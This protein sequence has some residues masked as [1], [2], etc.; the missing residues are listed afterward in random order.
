MKKEIFLLFV[1]LILCFISTIF[2]SSAGDSN[3][4]K[5]ST[6]YTSSTMTTCEGGKCTKIIYSGT[7][8]VY[9]DNVWKNIENARSLKN[10]SISCIVKEDEFASAECLDYNTTSI[11]LKIKLKDESLKNKDIDIKIKSEKYDKN[12]T[13][14]NFEKNVKKI[15]LR[16]LGDESINLLNCNFGEEI[17]I[18]ENS[19]IV[20]LEENDTENMN[21]VY[22]DIDFPNTNLESIHALWVQNTTDGGT[23]LENIL[24]MFNISSIPT[25]VLVTD[26]KLRLFSVTNGLDNTET[27]NLSVYKIYSTYA[28]NETAVTWNTRPINNATQTNYNSTILDALFFNSTS[29]EGIY[30]NWSLDSSVQESINIG[31]KNIS[32][33]ILAHQAVGTDY[34]VDAS[35]FC[36][37]DPVLDPNCN[38]TTRPILEITYIL[39]NITACR[40]FDTPGYY[41]LMNNLSSEGTCINISSDNVTIDGQ[42]YYI[43]HAQGGVTGMAITSNGYSNLRIEGFNLFMNSSSTNGD[44]ISINGGQYI[45]ISDNNI[46][47][48]DGSGGGDGIGLFSSNHTLIENCNISMIDSFTGNGH[49]INIQ[50]TPSSMNN[51]TIKNSK[52]YQYSSSVAG[53]YLDDQATFIE[54]LTIYNIYLYG[55]GSSNNDGILIDLDHN[56]RDISANISSVFISNMGRYGISFTTFHG[57]G[58]TNPISNINISNSGTKDVY[59]FNGKAVFLNSTYISETITSGDS[60]TRQWYYAS[61]V[62]NT[63][64]DPINN[65]NVTSYNISGS[66]IFN[67]TTDATGYTPLGIATEYIS[68]ST[69]KTYQT[70]HNIYAGASG[71]PIINHTINFSSTLNKYNDYFTLSADPPTITLDSPLN[72]SF[73]NYKLNVYVNFTATDLNLIDTCELWSDWTGAWHKNQTFNSVASGIQVSTIKNLTDSNWKWNVWCNNTAGQATFYNSN[74]TF[75]TDTIY[76]VIFQSDIDIDTNTNSKD[77]IFNVSSFTEANYNNSF[78]SVYNALGLIESSLENVSLTSSSQMN[79][80]FTVSAFSN[81]VLRVYIRDK[82]NN[83]NFTDKN[84]TT[85]ES[86]SNVGGGGGGGS[87]VEKIPVLGIDVNGYSRSY[88]P[89]EREVIFAKINEKCLKKK[90]SIVNIYGFA[91]KCSLT[92]EEL[93]RIKIEMGEMGFNIESEDLPIFFKL[94]KSKDYFQGYETREKIDNYKLFASVLGI[95]NPLKI[96]P[97]TLN[98]P[99]FILKSSGQITL[100]YTFSANKDL[101]SCKVLSE[102]PDLTCNLSNNQVTINYKIDRVNFFNKHFSGKISVSTKAEEKNIEIKDIDIKMQIYNLSFNFIGIPIWIVLIIIF[103]TLLLLYLVIRRFKK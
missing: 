47:Q 81:Y 40:N 30:Y 89:L 23:S 6:D 9:E 95:P 48:T 24:I 87:D 13:K 77:V 20:Y 27:Y 5:I 50:A 35:S 49:G 80:S 55:D 53:I 62:N 78:Y 71:Y 74:Y 86:S 100:K 38:A 83:L 14:N 36:P 22:V 58:L 66:F 67:L 73:L 52:I 39:N 33:Y 96:N 84:F 88:S 64:G 34:T 7:Q 82:A 4:L 57:K 94:F 61:Y 1:V 60:L 85:S 16:G 54:N 32:F 41:Y 17:H 59:V 101:K 44:G 72:N 68:N 43:F 46:T 45:T 42:G 3:K 56:N 93:G 91:E 69:G 63:I 8:F 21:D 19:T 18:G 70:P 51:I 26:S 28:W 2:L 65:V 76:P 75:V 99:F 103:I 12:G 37:A 102:T 92:I 98:R 11:K 31:D 90:S 97:P 10:S 25:G 79:G 29:S 15:K